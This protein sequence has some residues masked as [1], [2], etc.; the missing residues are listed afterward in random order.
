MKHDSPQRRWTL[1]PVMM[2]F[3]ALA[4]A[5]GLTWA[6]PSGEYQ[7]HG[8]G[9]SAAV[10]PGSYR[11]LPKEAGWQA[12]WPAEAPKGKAAVAAPVSP[13]AI[14]TSV[15]A[16]LEKSANLI[17]MVVLL[18]GM[19]GVFRATGAFDAGIERLLGLTGGR[20]N[21][22]TPV[23]MVILSAGSTFLGL[24]TEYLVFIP[25]IIAISQRLGMS[26]LFGFTMLTLSAKIGYLS[27]V[28]NPLALLVAQPIVGVP[29]FSGAGFRFALW[30]LFLSL[31]IGFVL[32]MEKRRPVALTFDSKPLSG[33]HFGII[34]VMLAA[35]AVLVG[36]STMLGWRDRQFA[37]L[38]VVTALVV[39]AVARMSAREGAHA[40][41]EG[42]NQ[43]TLAALLLGMARGVEIVLR[44]GR[45]LDTIIAW[46]SHH[47][48]DLAPAVVAPLIMGFE[49][50]LTLLIPS[51][52]AKAA[53]S[54]PIL[55]PVGQSV[56]VSGQITVLAFILGNGLVNMFSPTSGMLLAFLAA[57]G[58]PYGRWFR[59]ILP[60]FLVFTVI[61]VVALVVAVG[62]G[63]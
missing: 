11:E 14:F 10:V 53:L 50:V 34:L 62:I 29:V 40:F 2:M 42:M 32:M 24:V 41:V 28:S 6:L 51:T 27:S 39:A 12:L 19:L 13:V 1:E 21:V 16:G 9:E 47:V 37:A 30:V 17:F 22:L 20:V 5:V 58:I 48:A 44:D 59:L 43:M 36:G 31:G 4:I 35:L 23:V 38:Y 63:Y 60:L 7:R 61:A 33:R 56:G 3:V 26:A 46:A 15:P 8:S 54:I 55:G 18:G 57:G 45:I 49:M 25:V 52:S